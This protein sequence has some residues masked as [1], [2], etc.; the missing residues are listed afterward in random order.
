MLDFLES[1]KGI[2]IIIISGF[3]VFGI[4]TNLI[5]ILEGPPPKETTYV[6]LVFKDDK[7]EGVLGIGGENPTI[8]M[9]SS[10]YHQMQIRIVNGDDN[11]HLLVIENIASTKLLQPAEIDTLLLSGGERGKYRYYDA[12]TNATLGEF[13][14]VRV[15]AIDD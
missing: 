13:W 14:I 1:K 11:P 10:K 15:T 3:V 12:V 2:F 5:H 7:V 9:R 8:V 6:T 4:L